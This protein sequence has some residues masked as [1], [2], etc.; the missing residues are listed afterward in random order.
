M[1]RRW[2]FAELFAGVVWAFAGMML[3]GGATAAA[4]TAAAVVVR[5]SGARAVLAGDSIRLQLPFTVP[6][7]TGG[8]AAVWTLS[9]TGAKSAE[10]AVQFAAGAR[11]LSV[12]LPWPKDEKGHKAD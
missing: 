4:Q 8:R 7:I 9:P 10:T 12:T 1:K 11:A 2:V 5:E 6:A 3:A